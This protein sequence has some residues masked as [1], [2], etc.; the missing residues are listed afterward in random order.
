MR[1]KDINNMEKLFEKRYST[2]RVTRGDQECL[3]KSDKT[4]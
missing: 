2:Q 1:S 3:T 4:D